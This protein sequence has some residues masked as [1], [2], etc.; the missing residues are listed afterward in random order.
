MVWYAEILTSSLGSAARTRASTASLPGRKSSSSCGCSFRTR[1]QT[2]FEVDRPN[3]ANIAE[4]G[5][6][7]RR[8]ATVGEVVREAVGSEVVG[9]AIGGCV[10]RRDGGRCRTV[11][12]GDAAPVALGFALDVVQTW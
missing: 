1:R 12:G 4:V 5:G 8:R 3:Q 9:A 2:N 10:A 11:W 7:R 6:E